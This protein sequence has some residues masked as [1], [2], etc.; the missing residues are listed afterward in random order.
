MNYGFIENLKYKLQKRVNQLSSL[1]IPQLYHSYLTQLWEFFQQNDLVH[2]ILSDL[3]L[4][5]SSADNNA[6]RIILNKET[7]SFNTELSYIATSYFVIKRCVE[8]ENKSVEID[9]GYSYMYRKT[10]KYIDYVNFFH[11][12]FV[13]I[14][15]EYIDEQLDDQ[16]LLLVLLRRYKHKCEWFRRE[17]LFSIYEN[18]TQVGEKRLTYDLYEYLYDQGIEFSIEPSSASGKP[19]L[20]AAQNTDD[21]LIA[22]AKIFDPGK[23]KNIAY[24]TKGFNQIY[25]YTLDY[26]EPFGYLIIFKTCEEDLKLDFKEKAIPFVIYNN[27]TIFFIVIDICKHEK[28]ASKRGKLKVYNLKE[29]EL[30]EFVEKSSEENKL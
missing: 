18:N 27:K 5:N 7:L 21:P 24:L 14:L 11:N 22:D 16:K 17:K 2:G 4:R 28:S 29:D 9:I 30:I 20:I 12:Y 6:K 26:N 3:S 19:D 15:Y 10:T 25:Q 8:S 23:S 1:E 13:V